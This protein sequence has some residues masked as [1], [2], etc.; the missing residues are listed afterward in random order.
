MGFDIGASA[1]DP[2]ESADVVLVST[3]LP[4]VV[5][6]VWLAGKALRRVLFNFVWAMVYNVLGISIANGIL[7]PLLTLKSTLAWEYYR[8]ILTKSK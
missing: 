7:Y 4:T 6:A 3:Y 8:F 2:A 1:Y 5:H